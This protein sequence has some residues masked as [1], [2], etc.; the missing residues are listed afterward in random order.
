[1]PSSIPISHTGFSAMPMNFQINKHVTSQGNNV[2]EQNKQ[3]SAFF[4][5]GSTS[6]LELSAAL[7]HPKISP[8]FAKRNIQT[9]SMY[10]NND[11]SEDGEV[12]SGGQEVAE[13]ISRS[14]EN[15]PV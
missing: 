1:M 7:L 6:D 3:S 13:I 4:R 12:S 15:S 9:R 8:V 14:Y 10:V 11:E 5:R 2:P